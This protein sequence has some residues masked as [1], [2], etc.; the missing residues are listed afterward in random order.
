M[1][2]TAVMEAAKLMVFGAA[3]YT[4]S[5][6]K[7]SAQLVSGSNIA[8]IVTIHLE[9]GH[10]NVVILHNSGDVSQGLSCT[11]LAAEARRLGEQLHLILLQ[12]PLS[13]SVRHGHEKRDEFGADRGGKKE[14]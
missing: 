3:C 11:H 1:G 5:S 6:A 8:K 7:A 9:N 2:P 10:R 14:L 4:D 13:L 12:L